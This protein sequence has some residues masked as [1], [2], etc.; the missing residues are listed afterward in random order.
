MDVDEVL[1]VDHRRLICRRSPASHF[2]VI[3]Q[4]ESFQSNEG[5]HGIA[6]PVCGVN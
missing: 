4:P 1:P 2:N 5:L 6:L 3:H